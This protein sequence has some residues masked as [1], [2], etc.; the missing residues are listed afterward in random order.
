[1]RLVLANLK[2]VATALCPEVAGLKSL[3]HYNNTPTVTAHRN[4]LGHLNVTFLIS[5]SMGISVAFSEASFS[6][7]C[8]FSIIYSVHLFAAYVFLSVSMWWV[9][10]HLNKKQSC[11]LQLPADAFEHLTSLA[12][13]TTERHSHPSLAL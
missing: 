9:Y 1:V 2:Q 13:A 4:L 8:T 3:K 12:G 11:V 6:Q 7:H 10:A 5:M